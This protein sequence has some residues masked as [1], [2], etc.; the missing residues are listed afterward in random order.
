[1]ENQFHLYLEQ[2]P[3][4]DH[5]VVSPAVIRRLPRYFRYLRELIRQDRMRVSSGELSSMMKITASQIRQDLNCFG[6][7]GQQGYGYNVNYLYS[8]ICS[9]LGV[10]AGIRAVVIGAGD[11]GRALVRSPMFEKRGVEILS[12]FDVDPKQIGREIAGIT[13]RSMEALDDF[14]GE[15][16]VDM[17]VLTLPKDQAQ[18]AASHLVKLGINGFWNF[19]GKDIEFPKEQDIIV[20]NVHLGDS[21]MSLNYRLCQRKESL[22]KKTEG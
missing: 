1:M 9:L 22:G 10:D 13:V 19:T 2:E 20:E 3:N 16:P 11:L 8:K 5:P 12:L 14:C 21:L 6:G 17:A 7:F 18:E 4:A 15:L